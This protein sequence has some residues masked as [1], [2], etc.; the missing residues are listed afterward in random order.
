M[1]VR[2]MKHRGVPGT[3]WWETLVGG[4][5]ACALAAVPAIAGES[6][7]RDGSGSG[8]PG[9]NLA[10]GGDETIG[11]LPVFGGSAIDLPLTRN[12]RGVRPAFTLEGSSADLASTVLGARGQGYVTVEVLDPATERLRLG[13]HGD[14]LVV[15]DRDLASQLPID[16]GIG[17]PEAFGEGQALVRSTDWAARRVQL[18]P[19]VLPLP[20]VPA[21][22]PESIEDV[23]Y[24]VR[25]VNENGIRT[26]HTLRTTV[27]L[28]VLEQRD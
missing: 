22:D 8:N 26:S 7:D 18:R 21:A 27:D 1:K 12:W 16:L 3:G 2:R 15:L 25:T 19:G 17:V 9:G 23:E 14:V 5:V 10:A 28:V 20:A 13:F 4:A 24:R 11:T 6:G